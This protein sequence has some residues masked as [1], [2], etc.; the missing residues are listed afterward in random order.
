MNR[1]QFYAAICACLGTRGVFAEPNVTAPIA[2]FSPTEFLMDLTNK[3]TGGKQ[4]WADRWFFHDWRIQRHALTGHCRLLDGNDRRHA[5]G[6][7][8]A[9]RETLDNICRRDKLPAMQGKAVIV[10][11]GLFRT[12]SS[13]ARL[14]DALAEGGEYSVFCLGYPTTR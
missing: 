14:R 1:R 3:T 7:F 5:W 11:H 8:E 6:T 12:R 2:G 4:F 13:M 9:C 10:L